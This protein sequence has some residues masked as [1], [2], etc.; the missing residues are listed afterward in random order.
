MGWGKQGATLWFPKVQT[1]AFARRSAWLIRSIIPIRL[2]AKF[3]VHLKHVNLFSVEDR[4]QRA[5]TQDL[6]SVRWVL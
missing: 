6:S 4:F 3:L 2:L 1:S 5:V